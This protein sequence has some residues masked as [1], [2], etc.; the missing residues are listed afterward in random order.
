MKVAPDNERQHSPLAAA[1]LTIAQEIRMSPPA[2]MQGLIARNEIESP[3]ELRK[4]STKGVESLD[5]ILKKGTEDNSER[6][7][8]VT[9]HTKLK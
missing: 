1:R 4:L 8:L 7:K 9:E 5:E 3:A 6:T 2:K